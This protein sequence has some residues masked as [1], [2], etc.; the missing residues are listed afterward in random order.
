MTEPH[1][2]RLIQEPRLRCFS[3]GV[4][5]SED[6]WPAAV[7]HLNNGGPSRPLVE[8]AQDNGS[9]PCP[10]CEHKPFSTEGWLIR[11]RNREHGAS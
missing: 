2:I 4:T 1:V 5:F 6:D 9:Y 7:A 8:A 3:C 11:H 10:D